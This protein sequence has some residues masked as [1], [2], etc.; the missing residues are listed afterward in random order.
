[1]DTIT[2]T[3]VRLRSVP[4]LSR[5]F[6]TAVDRHFGYFPVDTR[7]RVIKEHR[8]L[9]LLIAAFRSRRIILT[10][11]LNGRLIGYAIGNVPKDHHG[12][13]FW[14]YVEPAVRG[15]NT[16]LALL[17]RMIKLQ[18]ELGALDVTLATYDHRRYYERQGFVWRSKQLIDEVEL[19]IMTFPLRTQ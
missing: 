15:N 18:R 4:N 17:S 11:T 5:L 19:D 1:M 3:P 9:K 12:Q 2:I 16:G 14:L 8:P 13:F 10:A 7:L 6:V